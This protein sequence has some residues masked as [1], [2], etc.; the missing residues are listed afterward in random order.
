MLGRRGGWRGAGWGGMAG[1]PG[2]S[3]Q[4]GGGRNVAPQR[5]PPPHTTVVPSRTPTH[6]QLLGVEDLHIAN[7][8]KRREE[9]ELAAMTQWQRR[10]KAIN[11]AGECNLSVKG[12]QRCG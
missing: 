10:K 3:Q 7:E 12:H 9:Q 8:E 5:S 6:T 11:D 2:G 4:A 1:G